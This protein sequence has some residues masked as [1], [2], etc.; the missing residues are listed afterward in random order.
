MVRWERL[1]HSIHFP[2]SYIGSDIEQL[3]EDGSTEASLR[4][5]SSFVRVGMVGARRIIRS[6]TA[7]PPQQLSVP[8]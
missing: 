7:D 3:C 8:I 1:H 4:E 6:D 2:E 5:G